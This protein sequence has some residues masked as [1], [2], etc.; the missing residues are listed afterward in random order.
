M[1]VKDKRRV[2]YGGRVLCV[3]V[4]TTMILCPLT[5]IRRKNR[6]TIID[7]NVNLF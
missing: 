7:L 6:D 1:F 5:Q 3:E 4:G 2:S